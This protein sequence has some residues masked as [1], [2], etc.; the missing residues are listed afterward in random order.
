MC[1]GKKA[2]GKDKSEYFKH[3]KVSERVRHKPSAIKIEDK[4]T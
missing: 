2:G 3:F 1:R 4:A